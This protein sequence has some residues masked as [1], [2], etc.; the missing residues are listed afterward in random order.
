MC[1]S[2]KKEKK[3]SSLLKPFQLL[4]TFLSQLFSIFPATVLPFLS[5]LLHSHTTCSPC[6]SSKF[7]TFLKQR[8]EQRSV[9][10]TP[11]PPRKATFNLHSI[12]DFSSGAMVPLCS[13]LECLF[14]LLVFLW[15][16]FLSCLGVVVLFL[17]RTFF[18][19]NLISISK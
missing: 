19:S 11:Q 5:A 7:L 10:S 2:K 15:F 3:I 8:L 6:F 16:S 14:P 1:F 4:S 18:D 13:R 17:L 12:S 9:R